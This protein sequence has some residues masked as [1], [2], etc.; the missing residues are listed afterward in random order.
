MD[1]VARAIPTAPRLRGRIKI[2]DGFRL[3]L[4]CVYAPTDVTV[5]QT[6]TTVMSPRRETEK[7]RI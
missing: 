3:S 6:M 7:G 1:G 5:A 2:E 4:E